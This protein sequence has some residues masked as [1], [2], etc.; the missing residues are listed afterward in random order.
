[1]SEI[2]PEI[3]TSLISSVGFPI[4]CV[5]FLWQYVR[6]TMEKFTEPMNENNKMLALLCEKID[7]VDRRDD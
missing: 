7:H 2:T 5:L 6:T 1:M 4:V 3:V